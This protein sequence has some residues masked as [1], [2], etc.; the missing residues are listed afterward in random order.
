MDIGELEDFQDPSDTKDDLT[1]QQER[2]IKLKALVRRRIK[3]GSDL[4]RAAAENLDLLH[5]FF[6]FTYLNV[7]WII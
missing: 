6:H 7:L 4:K 5:F 1:N 3:L 2:D